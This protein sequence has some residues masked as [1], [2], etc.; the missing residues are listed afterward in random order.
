MQFL[1]KTGNRKVTALIQKRHRIRVAGTVI[2]YLCLVYAYTL[3]EFQRLKPCPLK[4]GKQKGRR[5]GLKPVV[6]YFIIDKSV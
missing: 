5:T 1:I 3:V 6:T 2:V 4:F